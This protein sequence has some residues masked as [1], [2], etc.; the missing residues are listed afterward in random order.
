MT[1]TDKAAPALPAV[2]VTG[3]AGF[4]GEI[5]KRILLERG[6]P[7]VSVDV[8]PDE[9]RHPNLTVLRGDL[10]DR[11]FLE[12]VFT[13]HRFDAIVHAAAVLA[14]ATPDRKELWSS[15]VEGTRLLADS[16]R[17]HGVPKLVFVS[18]NCLWAENL[19]RPV[20]E[21]DPPCPAELYGKSKWEGEKILSGY[22]DALNVVILRSPTIIDSGRLGLLAILYDFIL[23]G[24]RVWVV[25]SGRNRYQFLYAPDLAD[26][27]IRA[28]GHRGSAVFGVGSENVQPMREVYQYVIDAAKT[29]SRVASL[30]RGPTLFAMKAAHTLGISPLGP[31]HYK[32]IAEDFQFDTSAIRRELQ[33]RP[34]LT[35][36]QMLLRA[37]E[38]YRDNRDEILRRTAV[39]AH[40]K[41]APLGIIRLLKWLS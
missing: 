4:F 25:G 22:R 28:I 6:Y 33:W 36:G 38:Y 11:V 3:G 23:E 31:Y 14:H 19:G 8:Q 26:A 34:T 13:S 32:M 15:N 27:C 40:K 20:R 17:A 7:C 5:L 41:A 16:A 35:N 18:S 39:S 21:D 30:P 10:R 2:L 29:G 37:F 24:R 9:T 12:G 1:S